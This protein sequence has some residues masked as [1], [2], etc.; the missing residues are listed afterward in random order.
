MVQHLKR[1]ETAQLV[2]ASSEGRRRIYQIDLE[3]IGALRA[4][5]DGFWNQSL[6]AFQAAAEHEDKEHS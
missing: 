4:Y 5:L 1:L 6:A 2:E 3:G